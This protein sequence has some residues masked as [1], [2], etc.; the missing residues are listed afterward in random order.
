MMAGCATKA[1][2]KADLT[3]FIKQSDLSAMVTDTTNKIDNLIARMN[4]EA[5]QVKK[6][7]EVLKKEFHAFEM[8]CPCK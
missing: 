1:A 5:D 2:V 4:L 6:K 8:A 3:D 7:I